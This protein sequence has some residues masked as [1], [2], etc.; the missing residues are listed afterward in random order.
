MPN[1]IARNKILIP[2]L[3]K[4]WR[5]TAADHFDLSQSAIEKVAN[6]SYTNIEVFE[7]LVALAEENKKA[8][9]AKELELQ[10][11]LEELNK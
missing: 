4:N 7:Y 8:L 5:K 10:L 2:H 11:R 6:G 9:A 3:P 1:T